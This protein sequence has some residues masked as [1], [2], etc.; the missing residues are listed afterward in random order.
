MLLNLDTITKVGN[1][2]GKQSLSMRK[3]EGG[4]KNSAN[5]SQISQVA[6]LV[7]TQPWD[8]SRRSVDI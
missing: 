6:I 5:T 4:D 2:P 7:E 1:F 8:Y 3:L